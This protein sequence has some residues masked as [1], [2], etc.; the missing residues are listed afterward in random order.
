MSI[1]DC[2]RYPKFS[3]RQTVT[4]LQSG[5]EVLSRRQEPKSVTDRDSQSAEPDPRRGR[6]YNRNA[7]REMNPSDM[8]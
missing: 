3:R 2:A 8:F 4:S 1:N 6:L 5:T 7:S